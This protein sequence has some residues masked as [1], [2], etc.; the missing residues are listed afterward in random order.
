MTI[1]DLAW[2]V[3]L[4]GIV[5]LFLAMVAIDVCCPPREIKRARTIQRAFECYRKELKQWRRMNSVIDPRFERRG[6]K[7]SP[8]D[9]QGGKE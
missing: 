3:M 6:H 2:A 7:T 4:G 9:K 1:V 5:L 8:W